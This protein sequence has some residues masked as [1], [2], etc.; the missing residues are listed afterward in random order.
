[1]FECWNR[2]FESSRGYVLVCL[3]LVFVVHCVGSG[4]CDEPITYLEEFYRVCVCVCVYCV[5]V[6]VSITV[7]DTEISKRDCL[8]PNWAAAPHK[9]IHVK[10]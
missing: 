8:G 10:V 1:V 9:N 4:L 3:S 2:G 6:C 7:C 5:C